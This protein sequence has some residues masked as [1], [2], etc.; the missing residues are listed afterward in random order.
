MDIPVA[1]RVRMGTRIGAGDC[2][3]CQ[4]CVVS[5]PTGALTTSFGR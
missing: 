1:E 5:C 2:I 4:R 3:L